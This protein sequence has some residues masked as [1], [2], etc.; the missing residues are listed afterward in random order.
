M[1][2][3]L[4]NERVGEHRCKAALPGPRFYY[5]RCRGY[6]IHR[7]LFIQ[8]FRRHQLDLLRASLRL[9]YA[10]PQRRAGGVT[11]SSGGHGFVRVQFCPPT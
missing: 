10:I 5:I 2:E 11:A 8:L 1:P 3:S 7:D 9:G 4:R 6:R